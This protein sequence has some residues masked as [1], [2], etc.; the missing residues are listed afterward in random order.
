MELWTDVSP[1]CDDI[2]SESDL[3]TCTDTNISLVFGR[4]WQ[5]GWW[6]A[7]LLNS[8]F[9]NMERLILCCNYMDREHAFDL[10]L[11]PTRLK[12]IEIKTVQ[13]NIKIGDLSN[14]LTLELVG[15]YGQAGLGLVELNGILPNSLKQLVIYQHPQHLHHQHQQ[16]HRQLHDLGFIDTIGTRV[17]NSRRYDVVSYTR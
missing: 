4:T 2:R 15:I 13:S 5:P 17:L 11:L 7:N 3:E 1:D 16:N 10:S 6:L 9:P 12:S 8:K 14:H